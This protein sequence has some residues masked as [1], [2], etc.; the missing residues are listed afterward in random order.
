MP[1]LS[2]NRCNQSHRMDRGSH[3]WTRRRAI[4]GSSTAKTRCLLV[5][6]QQRLSATIKQTL[7]R[8]VCQSLPLSYQMSVDAALS[9]VVGKD[10]GT[11]TAR[12][13]ITK[14]PWLCRPKAQISRHIVSLTSNFLSIIRAW[15][16][17]TKFHRIRLHLTFRRR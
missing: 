3:G 12:I 5:L 10:L 14:C 15:T 6:K 16:L 11:L 1:L 13:K 17:G 8:V 2:L 7:R 4:P 9:L